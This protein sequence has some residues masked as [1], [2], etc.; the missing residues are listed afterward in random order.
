M[1]GADSKLDYT[2]IGKYAL[3]GLG[4]TYVTGKVLK[5][6][7]GSS[8]VTPSKNVL[9]IVDAEQN[10]SLYDTLFSPSTDC[11]KTV[12]EQLNE[13]PDDEDVSIIIKTYGGSAVWCLKICEA[14]K[15]RRD[16]GKG[17]ITRV[18]V[19]F[20]IFHHRKLTLL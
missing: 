4:A 3:I 16:S 12:Q 1:D 11:Y 14:I 2:T 10:G 20:S 17:G 15:N 9:H 8:S 13:I 5:W 19:K 18:Y 6:L 7:A